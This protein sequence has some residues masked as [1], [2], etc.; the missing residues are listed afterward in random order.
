MSLTPY[1]QAMGRGPSRGRNLTREEAAEAMRLILAGDAA[2]E[3]VGAL[4]MLMRY[5]GETAAEVAGF[6]DAIRPTVSAW[7]NVGAALDWPSYAAGRSRGLPWFLLSARLLGQAGV[8]VMLHGWNSHQGHAA[9]VRRALPDIGITV[10][11]DPAETAAV[12]KDR[13]VAYAPLEAISPRLLDLL[14]LRE[15]LGLRSAVNTTLRVLNPSAAPA[16]VQG[17]FHPPYRNLQQDVGALLAQPS[18]SVLKGGGGEFE[19]HPGKGVDLF[20][21]RDGEPVDQSAPPMMDATRRLADEEPKAEHLS[22]VWAGNHGDPFAKAIVTGTAALALWTV[23]RASTL[24]QAEILARRLW[25]ERH[26]AVAA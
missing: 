11:S 14:R 18:L 10:T 5:R 20:G 7:A 22:A 3:A 2:P 24:D 12:L 9:D 16:S 25:D 1:I 6:V 19:R 13:G 17:V 23:G 8:P 15:I 26:S 4:L 21:L